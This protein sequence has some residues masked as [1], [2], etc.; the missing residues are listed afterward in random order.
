MVFHYSWQGWAFKLS[1]LTLAGRGRA[2]LN[3]SNMPPLKLFRYSVPLE[4]SESPG[5]PHSLFWQQPS[6]KENM[7]PVTTE[8]G[9]K[10][11][12]PMWFLCQVQW[13]SCLPIWSAQIPP[14]LEGEGHFIISARA[15]RGSHSSLVTVLGWDDR[16]FCDSDWRKATTV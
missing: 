14:R 11:R 1:L 7:H 2:A 3:Y 9:W 5:F 8:W 16:F 15:G 6:R 13:K 10:P 12:P 4:S